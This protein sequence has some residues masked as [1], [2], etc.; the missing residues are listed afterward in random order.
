MGEPPGRYR[1]LLGTALVRESWLETRGLG[2]SVPGTV[3]TWG[4]APHTGIEVECSFEKSGSATPKSRPATALAKPAHLEALGCI[5]AW[6]RLCCTSC[7]LGRP[8]A[9]QLFCG[10]EEAP[11]GGASRVLP[12][13]GTHGE[14]ARVPRTCY[15]AACL[16]TCKLS[17][18]DSGVVFVMAPE[19]PYPGPG[20][21]RHVTSHTKGLRRW[22]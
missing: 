9:Q 11:A 16:S 21:C 4:R 2:S 5:P 13:P 15:P 10:P 17:S 7:Q 20:T 12:P 19:T 8:P 6:W 14:L 22:G 3:G 1:G 18:L